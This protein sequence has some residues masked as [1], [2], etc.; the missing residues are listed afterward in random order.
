MS[1]KPLLLFLVGGLLS[2][3]GLSQ[4]A[5]QLYHIELILFRHAPPVEAYQP[6]A[7]DWAQGT[8]SPDPTK[9]VPAGLNALIKQLAS[10]PNYRPLLHRSWNQSLSA[11]QPISLQLTQGPAHFEYF[12]LQ[13]RLQLNPGQTLEAQVDAWVN[14]FD[15]QGNL[16]GSEHLGQQLQL[17]SGILHYLDHSSLGALIQ[18]TRL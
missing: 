9:D 17:R 3:S 4:A 8:Q 7:F 1:T 5:E 13:I 15:A 16:V 2:L 18:V 6:P 12:P 11:N 10:A 14:R